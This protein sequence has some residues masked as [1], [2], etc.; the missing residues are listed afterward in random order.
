MNENLKKPDFYHKTITMMAGNNRHTVQSI[1]F[2]LD[3]RVI[4][5]TEN[6]E[7]ELLHDDSIFPH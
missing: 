3:N 1:P 7:K 5:A 6:G 2:G 4:N